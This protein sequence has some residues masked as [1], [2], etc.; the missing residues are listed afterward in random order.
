MPCPAVSRNTHP[1]SMATLQHAFNGGLLCSVYWPLSQHPACYRHP[2][3]YARAYSIRKQVKVHVQLQ[4][5]A[6]PLGR[7]YTP[8][9]ACCCTWHRS[10][11][12]I[13]IPRTWNKYLAKRYVSHVVTYSIS[14][15]ARVIGIGRS[16]DTYLNE[17]SYFSFYR[18][19]TYPTY[20]SW[21]T[22]LLLSLGY[23]YH[24]RGTSF[25]LF[26]SIALT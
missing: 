13:R 26:F 15:Q 9:P 19:V 21:V 10:P 24:V 20:V 1:E 2:R 6:P 4:A 16:P 14:N 22:F 25:S 11:R 8:P 17:S 3:T 12:E 23:L 5:L 7:L 18:S